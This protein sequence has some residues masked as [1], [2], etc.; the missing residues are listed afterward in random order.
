MKERPTRSQFRQFPHQEGN[1]AWGHLYTLYRDQSQWLVH[2]QLCGVP[3]R[4]SFCTGTCPWFEMAL[5]ITTVLSI[6][7]LTSQQIFWISATE[8]TGILV[9]QS[10]VERT[11]YFGGQWIL[12]FVVP[13]FFLESKQNEDTK[14]DQ[15]L[16]YRGKFANNKKRLLIFCIYYIFAICPILFLTKEGNLWIVFAKLRRKSL[17]CEKGRN[18]FFMAPH[19]RNMW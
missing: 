7:A 16:L 4:G 13:R 10:P 8:N 5:P 11:E 6:S 14:I 15:I 3:V 19:K 9:A 18:Q 17:F 1:R 2:R 12:L